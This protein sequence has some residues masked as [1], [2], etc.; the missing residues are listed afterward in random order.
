MSRRP[1]FLVAGDHVPSTFDLASPFSSIEVLE[2]IS[3]TPLA[4]MDPEV[5]SHQEDV[6][7]QDTKNLAAEP[8]QGMDSAISELSGGSWSPCH[9]NEET[10]TAMEQEGLIA[11]REISKWRVEPSATKPVPQ[12]KEVV[13]LKSHI[14]RGLSLPP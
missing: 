11:A 7:S 4:A 8:A 12:K 14:D 9:L 6:A 13:M 10:L 2:I 1:D 3:A 5:S